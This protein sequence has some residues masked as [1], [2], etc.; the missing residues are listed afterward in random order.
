[1]VWSLDLIPKNGSS[2]NLCSDSQ[3]FLS[4]LTDLVLFS[5]EIITLFFPNLSLS[6]LFDSCLISCSSSTTLTCKFYN[7]STFNNHIIVNTTLFGTTSITRTQYE[8]GDDSF[9][10]SNGFPSVTCSSNDMLFGN[11]YFNNNK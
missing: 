8:D 5:L 10:L 6:D 11:F 9:K 1:M 3:D 4:L 2:P 7:S